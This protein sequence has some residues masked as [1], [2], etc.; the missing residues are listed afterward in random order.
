M[1]DPRNDFY[2]ALND[3]RLVDARAAVQAGLYINGLATTAILALLASLASAAMKGDAG[4]G[5][6]VHISHAFIWGLGCF[7]AGVFL[8][9]LAAFGSYF[10]NHAYAELASPFQTFTC[11]KQARLQI[12]ASILHTLSSLSGLGSLAAFVSGVTA[13][14][15]G[16]DRIA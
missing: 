13:V 11:V 7:G 5:S 14:V 10:T 8:A 2:K 15:I 4:S 16:F 6:H 1:S 9:A 3:A 12:R